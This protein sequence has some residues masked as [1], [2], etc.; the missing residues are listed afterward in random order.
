MARYID[1]PSLEQRAR[2]PRYR[3]FEAFAAML[4]SATTV[5]VSATGENP[6]CGDELEVRL[7][8]RCDEG[9]KWVVERAAFDGYGCTLCLAAADAVMDHLA[10]LPV[11]RAAAVDFEDTCR[12]LGGLEVGRTRKGCVDLAS[13]VVRDALAS[14]AARSV[15]QEGCADAATAKKA[16]SLEKN[17]V[18]KSSMGLAY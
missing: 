18:D 8:L 16:A 1:D 15:V 9:G 4:P 12:L 7:V 14:D 17:A 13:R 6:F 3:G 11:A 10:G 2:N 5:I